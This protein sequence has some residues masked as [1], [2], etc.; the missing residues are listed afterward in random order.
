VG[1]D[2]ATHTA[3][4]PDGFLGVALEVSTIPKWVGDATTPAQVNPVLVQLLRNLNPVGAPSIRVGGQSTDRSWWPVPKLND[5]AGVTY[6]IGTSW[7][8]AA[9][10][11]AERMG[12]RYIMSVNLEANSTRISQY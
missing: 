3:P 1:V 10:L 12:A 8:K 2:R 9:L 5:P 11:L 6:A 4:L 7:A